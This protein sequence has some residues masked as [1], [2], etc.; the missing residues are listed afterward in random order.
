VC[1]WERLH[2]GRAFW[3]YVG[4]DHEIPPFLGSGMPLGGMKVTLIMVR[5]DVCRLHLT[6]DGFP[7][8]GLG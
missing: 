4:H 8:T 3:N 2:C 6:T 7:V 5:L 1:T